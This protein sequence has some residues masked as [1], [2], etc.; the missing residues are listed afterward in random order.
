MQTSQFPFKYAAGEVI[1]TENMGFTMDFSDIN[2]INFSRRICLHLKLWYICWHGLIFPTQGTILAC[3][4]YI[5]VPIG[6][7]DKCL[8]KQFRLH[9]A[10]VSIMDLL[11]K[12]VPKT[13][14]DDNPVLQE[15]DTINY[16]KNVPVL[17]IWFDVNG[18]I[19]GCVWP[20][21][22]DCMA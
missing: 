9:N 20:T 15:N 3:S 10:Q 19:F 11:E 17:G 18:Q 16:V 5:T 13:H 6:P 12:S 14:W 22:L 7:I 8:P 1:N 2:A 4:L 21:S